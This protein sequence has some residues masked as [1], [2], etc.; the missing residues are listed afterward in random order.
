VRELH[1]GSKVTVANPS[2]LTFVTYVHATACDGTSSST[3]AAIPCQITYSCAASAC[4][5][6]VRSTSGSGS[7]AATTV[8]S[9][10]SSSSVFTYTPSSAAP[11]YVGVSFTFSPKSGQNGVTVDDG[12]AL[13][14][15]PIS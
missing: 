15:L 3:A 13:G 2:L 10:L 7:A 4:T 8:V 6:T 12:T 1:Q 9:G 5:R 14:N 11:T